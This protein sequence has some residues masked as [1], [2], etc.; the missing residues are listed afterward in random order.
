MT[1]LLAALAGML[2]IVMLA[3]GGLL[4]AALDS[5]PLVERSETISPMAVASARWLL[6]SNDPRRLQS[7]DARRAAIPAALIDEGINY[8][9]SRN[10]RGRG[11]LVLA[12]ETAEIRLTLRPPIFNGY[13]NLRANLREA[14]GEPHLTSA[15]IGTLPLPP[16]LVELVLHNAIRLAGFEHEWQLA[17]RALRSLEF[18]PSRQR[19]I[20]SYVWE[21]A[22][23][24]RAR[25]IAVSPQ[26][27]ARIR[28]AHEN[29]AGLLDH[30]APGGRVPLV[31][32]LKPMLDIGGDD[33]YANRRAAILAVAAYLSEKNLAHVIPEAQNWPR[34][35][36]V[37]LTLLGR[38]DSAQHFAVSAA[39]AAW[40]GEPIADAIGVYKE[41]LDARHGSGF[42]FADL[43][44]DRAGT[45]FGQLLTNLPGRIDRLLASDFADQ[46][47]VPMLNDLPESIPEREFRRRFGAPGSP[48]YQKINDE[49]ERRLN[50]LPLY[51]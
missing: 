11:A 38:G 22:L 3:A 13:I 36:P 50:D 28:S 21:P 35:R 14:S 51:Q 48:G 23:L 7:G 12:E 30:K 39:L 45:R 1:R 43:A 9:A 16:W 42:S 8:L 37:L 40:A 4:I 49:I 44:A 2:L 31:E 29:L 6:K 19:V 25:N 18:D 17:K 47:L 33:Q 20:V 41:L 27:V 32:V 46:A 15:S 5:K 34:L 10:L 26:D 24:D